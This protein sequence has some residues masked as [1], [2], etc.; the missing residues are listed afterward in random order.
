MR[1]PCHRNQK[2]FLE[3]S[4]TEV[5]PGTLHLLQPHGLHRDDG[6]KLPEFINLPAEAGSISYP[7]SGEQRS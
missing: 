7:G 3:A 4:L 2:T 5:N 1:Q 6:I